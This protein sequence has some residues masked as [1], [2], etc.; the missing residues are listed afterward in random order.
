MRKST[1][2]LGLLSLVTTVIP[3]YGYSQTALD[4]G[5]LQQQIER[6]SKDISPSLKKELPQTD[7]APD[8]KQAPV[9]KDGLTITVKQFRFE[10][11]ALLE[12]EELAEVVKSY[13]GH[14]VS[15]SELQ[16]AAAAIGDAYREKGWVVRSFVPEQAIA[17]G[18]VTIKI[19]EAKFGQAKVEGDTDVRVKQDRIEALVLAQQKSNETINTKKIDRA[20]LLV[21]DLPGISVSGRLRE[22]ERYGETDLVLKP[23]KEALVSGAAIM[24]NAGSRSTGKERA[25]GFAQLANPLGI[26]DMTS[27]YVLG[28]E[29]VA[30]AR[31]EESIPVGNHGWRIGANASAMHYDLV[32][33]EFKGLDGEGSAESIGLQ[34]NY[35]VIRGREKNLYL[36]LNYDQKYFENRSQS[37][38]SS[39]YDIKSGTIAFNGNLIDKLGGGGTNS[40]SL[41]MNFGALDLQAINSGEDADLDGSF[42]K[43]SYSISRIQ[44]LTEAFSLYASFSGQYSPEDKLDSSEMFYLGGP[45]GVRAYPVSEGGGVDGHL[46]T[47]E[48]RWKFLESF[49][50]TGFYDHGYV[51]NNAPTDSYTLDGAGAELTWQSKSGVNL[52]ATWAHRIGDNPNPTTT[53]HDQDG[54][55]LNNRF[56]LT[57]SKRF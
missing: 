55:L 40:A 24:D 49:Q 56:W 43:F 33:R 32:A 46:L 21:D 41:G 39:D 30:F 29:G 28:S 5:A 4:A 7:I 16:G 52:S 14:P 34:A 36:N 27:A 53:G 20:L 8:V 2:S 1:I 6:G 44:S 19:I 51:H 17:D 42:N 18:I 25:H 3:E 38:V 47:T 45:Q 37:A 12:D 57:L 50:L 13:S 10:G 23:T 22:G 35:P 31:L 26:G 9:V 15:F 48:L 54:S 11:N